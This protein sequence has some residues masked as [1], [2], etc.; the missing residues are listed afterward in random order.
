MKKNFIIY[1]RTKIDMTEPLIEIVE[2]P[3]KVK[4]KAYITGYQEDYGEL[5]TTERIRSIFDISNQD[6]EMALVV[7]GK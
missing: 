4:L 6:A 5:P 3:L 2:A 1:P 7:F